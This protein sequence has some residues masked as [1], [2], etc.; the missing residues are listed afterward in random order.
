MGSNGFIL[1]SIIAATFFLVFLV[2]TMGFYLSRSTSLV[3]LNQDE[4]DN[5]GPV[6]ITDPINIV[7]S[8]VIHAV[9]KSINVGIEIYN[10]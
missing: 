1:I 8:V 2:A 6:K 10:S 4:S 3:T 5:D 7:N 9:L